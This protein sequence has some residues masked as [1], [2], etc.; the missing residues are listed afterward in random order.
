MNLLS[1]FVKKNTACIDCGGE[2]SVFENKTKRK[3]IVS[4]IVIQC[5][6][7]D[8]TS[9][10]MTSDITRSRLYDNNIRLVYGLRSVGLGRCAG[11]MICSVL[12][13]PQPPTKFSVYNK[14][15]SSAVAEV[16]E[17]TMLNAVRESMEL[18]DADDPR[19]I[20]AAFDGSWQKR[21]HTSLNGIV[22]AT[23]FDTGKILDVEILSKFCYVCSTSPALQ[24]NYK[25]NYEG[26]SGGMEVA[27][28]VNLFKRSL[29]VRGVRYTRYLGDGDCKAFQTV[30]NEKPYGPDIQINKLECIG[31]VQKRM[32]TRLRNLVKE[33]SGIKLQDGKTLG[34]KG[35]L[36]KAEID[37]TQNYSIMV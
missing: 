22:S 15:L 7:C 32:G 4:N 21:G 36:T 33:K 34:G 9:N 6:E 5:M 14:T 8:F 13:I 18:N 2:I 27:G 3:G 31:H 23:S 1:E 17:G 10:T 35:R 16:S 11:K 20:A 30:V 12:N 37:K 28:V 26:S 24:H 25:K 29:G 19:N